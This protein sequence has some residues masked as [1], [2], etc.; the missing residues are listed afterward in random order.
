MNKKI[1]PKGDMVASQAVVAVDAARRLA[2]HVEARD[3]LAL[4]VN[5]LGIH[6]ALQA[7]HASGVVLDLR[8]VVQDSEFRGG[9]FLCFI[10]LALA[11]KASL[12]VFVDGLSPRCSSGSRG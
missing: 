3:D 2:S 4:L 11:A 6:R 8:I 1:S 7:T 10:S 5:A 9:S 12:I